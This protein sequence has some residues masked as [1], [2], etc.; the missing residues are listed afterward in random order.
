MMCVSFKEISTDGSMSKQVLFS[1]I[2]LMEKELAISQEL[3]NKLGELLNPIRLVVPSCEADEGK[4]TLP[5]RSDIA[6]R[7]L[8]HH[9][10]LKNLNAS[11]S[12]IID[13]VEL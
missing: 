5:A 10:G 6:C 9:E 13:T 11:I 4:S 3:V 8:N 12:Y 1:D 2:D 7:I